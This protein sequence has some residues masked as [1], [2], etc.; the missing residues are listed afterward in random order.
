MCSYKTLRDA[1]KLQSVDWVTTD[2]SKPFPE[3]VI[4]DSS[5][6]FPGWVITDSS[7][8]FP[9]WV[10]T[11]SSKPFPDWVIT[12][13]SKP[14]PDWVITDS[15]NPTRRLGHYR[16]RSRRWRW[17]IADGADDD[18]QMA[19]GADGA[20]DAGLGLRKTKTKLTFEAVFF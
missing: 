18:L 11:D 10:I 6:L 19:D 13:S 5:K 12:D 20:C 14:F 9:D 4:T 17:Q 3:W 7:K 15:S 8:L 1:G 2:S 16:F